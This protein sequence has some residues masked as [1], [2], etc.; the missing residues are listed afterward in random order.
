MS[1]DSAGDRGDQAP[2]EPAPSSALAATPSVLPPQPLEPAA[3]A[4]LLVPHRCVTEVADERGRP[5]CWDEELAGGDSQTG[6]AVAAVGRAKSGRKVRT[7]R[8]GRQPGARRGR[9]AWLFGCFAR[10]QTAD[11]EPAD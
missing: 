7:A 8:I 2:L 9:P 6:A 1:R 10:P 11:G 5:E 4:A 3:S